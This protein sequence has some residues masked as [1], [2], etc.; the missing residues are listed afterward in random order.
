MK[1][2]L[3]KIIFFIN[4]LTIA[5][6]IQSQQKLSDWRNIDNAYS[7]IPDE[8]YS[9][10]PYFVINKNG[11][12]VCIMTTGAGKEGQSGQH[13]VA[14][15]S[16]DKG[17]TWSRLID[18]E[19]ADGPEASWAVPLEVPS[20]RIYTFY[21]YNYE[22][23]REILMSNNKY[24]KRVDTF[25]K[26]MMKYSDD[27]GY[28]WSSKRYEIPMRNFD[29]DNN[30]VY[31][32]KVQMFWSVALPLIGT[33]G[34]V[35]F[36]LSKVGNFG[37]GLM[38]SSVGAILK[39]NNI[40]LES[41]PDKIIWETLPDGKKGL[42]APKGIVCDEHNAVFLNEEGGLYCVARTNQGHNVQYYSYDNGH[43]WT[44]P[45]WVSYEPN[46]KLMKQP[47]CFSKIKKFSNGKYIMFFHNN[48]SRDYHHN[49]WYNRNP[50]WL[51]GGVEKNGK[52]YWSQPEIFLYD[53]NYAN[54]I[55]YPD[56]IETDSCYYF[57]QTQ[58]TIARLHKI[59]TEYLQKLWNQIDLKTITSISPK[60]FLKDV[61]LKKGKEFEI[62]LLGN[63]PREGLS[64]GD[65][66][67]L[68]F[69]LTIPQ[70]R[71]DE[72]LLDTRK[73]MDEGVGNKSQYY[74]NGFVVSILK[75]NALEFKLI[76][77][78]SQIV[79]ATEPN[80]LKSNSENHFVI[81]VDAQAKVITFVING[82]LW[83][84]GK[85][86]FGYTRFDQYLYDINGESKVSFSK[87]FPGK[88]KFFRLY[89]HCIGT[90]DA[91]GNYRYGK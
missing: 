25:G 15:I 42:Q 90:T 78:R 7:I 47:R 6:T 82:D 45:E 43:T 76:D 41:D 65:G 34:A 84:G 74:G 61:D 77:G 66:F 89:D 55:S 73:K 58:K 18:I 46:G 64:R 10:Q 60:L 86:A 14:T 28:T 13:I 39:S 24:L 68:E 53:M 62:P 22:N 63:P 19:P 35:Y 11:E 51:C 21:T 1:T 2:T 38:E 57:S 12:F 23:R 16:K 29:I 59:P 48:S 72:V 87:T 70:M 56:W 69:K 79:H 67:S 30:N 49:P 88:I 52:I 81:N 8:G 9:D 36:P 71:K 3:L 50:T 91:I 85:R 37:D 80:V 83:D 17:K 32:G 26:M 33:D 31:G 5:I 4:L 75:D 44:E 27:G 20:G 40:L 54:G